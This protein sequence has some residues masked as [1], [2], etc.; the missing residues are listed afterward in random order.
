MAKNKSK[1]RS[2]SKRSLGNMVR[3]VESA[4]KTAIPVMALAAP[5]VAGALPYVQSG[6]IDV[7]A[8]SLVR[9]YTGVSVDTGKFDFAELAKGWTP[10]LVAKVVKKAASWF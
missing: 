2:G 4:V 6:N 3:K 9:T 10:Y 5:G 8:K 1:K 7:A